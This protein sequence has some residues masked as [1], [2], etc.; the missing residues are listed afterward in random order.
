[1][2]GECK[3]LVVGSIALDDIE[4]PFAKR[5]EVLGGAATYSS[6]AASHFTP[7]A[8]V[9]VVGDDFPQKHMD[10]FKSRGID[11]EGLQVVP[12]RTFRWA[13]SYHPNMMGRDTL[14][15]QL[16][17]FE[18]F[19]PRIP[20]RL[21]RCPFVLL[22]NIHP[23]LQRDVLAQL[24]DPLLTAADTMNFWIHGAGESLAEMIRQVDLL[25]LNDEEARDLTGEAS[26]PKAA[27]RI[28]EMGPRVV[29][30]K[31]GEHG[32]SIHLDGEVSFI[33]PYPAREVH[34]PTGAGDTFAGGL[35]GRLAAAA[36]VNRRSLRDAAFYGTALASFSIEEFGP[37]HVARVSDAQLTERLAAIQ[38]TLRDD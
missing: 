3:V 21:R 30:I 34:D 10:L 26:L 14:D 31:R 8:I 37:E 25:F 2:A 18:G 29:I 9:G 32:A 38:R 1:M 16:G 6:C 24:D 35:I 36:E 13:G 22:G 7:V 20:E 19:S 17:V 11:T 4:T 5:T 23:D 15:T 27:D 33:P 28:H 12:G